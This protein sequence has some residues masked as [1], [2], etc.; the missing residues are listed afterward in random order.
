[1]TKLL[2]QKSYVIYACMLIVTVLFG[3]D[4]GL[5]DCGTNI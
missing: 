2:W 3:V 5:N 1:M 4:V